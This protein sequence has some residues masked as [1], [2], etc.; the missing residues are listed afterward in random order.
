MYVKVLLFAL[1]SLAENE[2]VKLIW[3][4]GLTLLNWNW[5]HW[6]AAIVCDVF[7][8]YVQVLPTARVPGPAV[9]RSAPRTALNGVPAPACLR[10][11]VIDGALVFHGQG[12]RLRGRHRL[13]A[14]PGV[15]DREDQVAVSG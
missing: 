13:A 8:W 3:V 10:H 11:G 5:M 6:P 2:K 14:D 1:P 9:A 12:V 4:V 7:S 15:A